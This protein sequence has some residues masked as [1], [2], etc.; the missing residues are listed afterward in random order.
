MNKRHLIT[1]PPIDQL[2][3]QL[4]K[5]GAL[6]SSKSPHPK[7]RGFESGVAKIQEPRKMTQIWL[8]TYLMSETAITAYDVAALALYGNVTT[9]NFSENASRYLIP[10]LSSPT[11]I[12]QAAEVAAMS[13]PKHATTL[14]EWSRITIRPYSAVFLS[15]WASVTT[16][17]IPFFTTSDAVVGCNWARS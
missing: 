17:P 15:A 1:K 16:G 14:P 9:V 8:N 11:D 6:S 13:T 12:R 3:S 7:H 2:E 4:G 10:A 5:L